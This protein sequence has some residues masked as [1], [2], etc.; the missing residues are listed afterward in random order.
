MSQHIIGNTHIEVDS[1][2]SKL[3]MMIAFG[4]IAMFFVT[5]LAIAGSMIVQD[6][7]RIYLT[8]FN[9]TVVFI[10]AALL[11]LSSVFF[12]LAFKSWSAGKLEKT[13]WYLISSIFSA[14]LF[15]VG[16]IMIYQQLVHLGFSASSNVVAGMI[17]LIGGVH[18]AHI[19]SG[20]GIL[21]WLF[22][23][24][25]LEKRLKIIRFRLIGWYWH[26]LTILWFVVITVL[27]I[28]I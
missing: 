4:A 1:K 10:I 12:K 19:V 5:L 26:F 15:I 3:G 7:G 18:A 13:R 17:Y 14:V 21:L 28:I 9:K 24:A 16:Q 8:T 23:W 2:T 25:M 6:L 20:M 22:F 27:L 11:V